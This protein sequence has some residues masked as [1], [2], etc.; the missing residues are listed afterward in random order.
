MSVIYQ[1]NSA[2]KEAFLKTG[3]VA[4]LVSQCANSICAAANS[5][6]SSPHGQGV[7]YK[8]KHYTNNKGFPHSGVYTANVYACKHERKHGTLRNSV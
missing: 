3:G 8:V 2:G 5:K 7:P 4:A 1:P 6:A